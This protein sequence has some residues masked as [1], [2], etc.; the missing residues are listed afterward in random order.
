MLSLAPPAADM[1]HGLLDGILTGK[2]PLPTE[3]VQ[4]DDGTDI[5]LSGEA[6]ESRGVYTLRVF[7]KNDER[8]CFTTSTVIRMEEDQAEKLLRELKVAT[9]ALT[10][11]AVGF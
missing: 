1:V 6:S 8:P 7:I 2:D 5:I 4:F 9:T 11:A 3:E 10:P